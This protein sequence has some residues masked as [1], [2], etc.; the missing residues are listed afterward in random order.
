MLLPVRL[1]VPAPL[2]VSVPVPEMALAMVSVPVRLITRALLL[3]VAPV[4]SAPVAPLPICRVPAEIVV[5][6]L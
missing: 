3:V 2:W 5:V 4:P 1:V 6:P